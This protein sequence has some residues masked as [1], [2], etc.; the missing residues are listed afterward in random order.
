MVSQCCVAS[1]QDVKFRLIAEFIKNPASGCARFA[2]WQGSISFSNAFGEPACR[3]QL[4][5]GDKAWVK[6]EELRHPAMGLRTKSDFIP[7]NVKLGGKDLAVDL[8]VSTFVCSH[9]ISDSQMLQRRI[10]TK[11]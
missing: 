1:I 8:S 7:N 5:E 9:I 2:S 3:P 11:L 6:F 10:H 4:V